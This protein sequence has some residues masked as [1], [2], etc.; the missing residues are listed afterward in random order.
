MLIT[1]SIASLLGAAALGGVRW[2][3]ALSAC[4]SDR[5]LLWTLATL[6]IISSVAALHLMNQFQPLVSPAVASVVYCTEPLFATTFSIAFRTEKLAGM[7]IA[8]GLV[9]LGSVLIVALA[10]SPNRNT[11]SD[12]A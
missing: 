6:I 2:G 5:T 7:T 12:G 11:Q 8:G 9:V 4:A 1:T 10:P 3:P